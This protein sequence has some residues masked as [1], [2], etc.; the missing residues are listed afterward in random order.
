MVPVWIL[1]TREVTPG[2]EQAVQYH[3]LKGLLPFPL[4]AGPFPP[5]QQP[6]VRVHVGG[7]E[8]PV[9][10]RVK[11]EEDPIDELF[12]FEG[13]RSP[14]TGCVGQASGQAGLQTS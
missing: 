3:P 14:A 11:V 13:L 5:E 9:I 7:P 1:H 8:E 12:P 4:R 2:D 10:V 6:G